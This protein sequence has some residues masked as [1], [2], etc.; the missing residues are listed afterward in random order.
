M[1]MQPQHK[2]A[3][4]LG[5]RAHPTQTHAPQYTQPHVMPLGAAL[6]RGA[7]AGNG[8][9][10]HTGYYAYDAG[11]VFSGRMFAFLPTWRRACSTCRPFANRT[12]LLKFRALTSWFFHPSVHGQRPYGHA[13]RLQGTAVPAG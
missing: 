4:G 2:M 7:V 13:L 3:A 12:A 11:Q 8:I 1:A 5:A 10:A 9:P 6:G